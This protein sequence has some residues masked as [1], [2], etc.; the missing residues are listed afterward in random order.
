MK[1]ISLLIAALFVLTACDK[2]MQQTQNHL[3]KDS[4]KADELFDTTH[5]VIERQSV[6]E[7]SNDFFV[8]S[9]SYQIIEEVVLPP[10]FDKEIIYSSSQQEP[11]MSVLADVY[12]QTDVNFKFTPDA[13]GH[14]LGDAQAGDADTTAAVTDTASETGEAVSVGS[15][16]VGSNRAVLG[17]V[18]VSM[19]YK[20]SVFNFVE[21]LGTQFDIYWEY[22]T[23]NKT[24]I[25]YRTKTKVLALDLLPGITTFSNE[26]TSSS[27][28]GG[29]EE[30]ANLN[31]G[32]VMNV[33]YKNNEANGWKDTVSTIEAM[34][35]NEGKVNA[36]LR[37]GLLTV[38]DIPERLARVEGYVNK[39]NDKGRKKIAVKVDVFD[40]ALTA[41][42]DYGID[43]TTVIKELGGEFTL[44][45]GVNASPIGTSDI[46]D[47]I[48]FTYSGGGFFKQIDALFRALS[49]IGD[50]TKVTGTTVYT[51]NGEP[52]PVQVVK[53]QDYIKE[54][55]FSAVSDQSSTTEVAVTPGTVISGFFMIITPT[56]LSDNQILLNLSFSLSTANLDNAQQVCSGGTGDEA[57]C[58]T[59]TLPLVNSKNFMES[60]TLNPGQTVILSGFQEVENQIGISSLAAPSFWALG[61]NKGA[62]STKN[63]TVTVVTPYIIGR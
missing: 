59:I 7:H 47:N 39:I 18:L 6:V 41:S 27:T 61:G 34:L 8:A 58:T 37:S 26:M 16:S 24:V 42:T 21:R 44:D 54:I 56:I 60:V 33:T 22:D 55:T 40:V 62:K 1:K 38:T 2:N 28:I 9:K 63:T 30:G 52:A 50:T 25:Y 3:N 10:I 19:Q 29:S 15:S 45:S 57:S 51:V 14:I 31:S 49:K 32:A 46:V 5:R 20:G 48:K 11:L 4:N 53:R 43:W 13:I 17:E 23:K 35:S 12:S 36:N